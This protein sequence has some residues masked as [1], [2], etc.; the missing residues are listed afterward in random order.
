MN[1]NNLDLKI[2]VLRSVMFNLFEF[3]RVADYREIHSCFFNY[4]GKNSKKPLTF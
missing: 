4:S 3:F 1:T 2:A